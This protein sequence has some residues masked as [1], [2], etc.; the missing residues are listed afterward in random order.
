MVAVVAPREAIDP[1][2]L[3]VVNNSLRV[4]TPAVS[5]NVGKGSRPLEDV[6]YL[7]ICLERYHA[8]DDWSAL[9]WLSDLVK[10]AVDLTARGDR[11]L[12]THAFRALVQGVSRSNDLT[13]FDRRTI[14]NA[15]QERLRAVAVR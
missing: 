14:V 13:N 12:A 5:G 6:S 11:E 8:R 9:T 4:G 3:C 15:V 1:R 7:L 10:E 2:T